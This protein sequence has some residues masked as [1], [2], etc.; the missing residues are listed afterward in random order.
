MGRLMPKEFSLTELEVAFEKTTGKQLDKRNF[1]KKILKFKM[2]K[3][4]PKKRTGTPSRPAQLYSFTSSKVV[5][6]ETI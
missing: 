3:K 4:L 1:R 2:L 5:E 6:V